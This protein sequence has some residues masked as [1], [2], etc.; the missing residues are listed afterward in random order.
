MDKPQLQ[1]VKNLEFSHHFQSFPTVANLKSAL[2]ASPFLQAFF[3]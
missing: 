3:N 1:I 2:S